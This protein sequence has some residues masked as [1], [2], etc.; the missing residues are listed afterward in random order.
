MIT[1]SRS[2]PVD[3]TFTLKDGGFE[4]FPSDNKTNYSSSRTVGAWNLTCG[5][6]IKQWQ[7]RLSDEYE[8]GKVLN[9][10]RGTT[11]APNGKAQQVFKLKKAG[12]YEYRVK[13]YATDDTW[14][15]YLP[16]ATV[17]QNLDLET[18]L[19]ESCNDT[20][21]NTK[22]IH[23]VFFG[24]N[25]AQGDSL[26]LYK[27]HPAVL[28]Y[29]RYTPQTYSVIYVKN[30]DNEEEF[31]LGFEVYDNHYDSGSNG[32]GFGDNHL[33]Y[34][35]SEAAYKTATQAAFEQECA[36]AR[37]MIAKYPKD[38]LN[39]GGPDLKKGLVNGMYRYMGDKDNHPVD[40]KTLIK[41]PTT[42]QE[43]QNAIISLQENQK[44]L[45]ELAT[46]I[47]P[48]DPETK[49]EDL[50]KEENTTG[51]AGIYTLTGVRI[52]SNVKNLP[53]GL[54]IINGKKVVIK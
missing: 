11:V 2:N 8:A 24:P 51:K 22:P 4:S 41:T 1:A 34:L 48:V 47:A 38:S 23:K 9:A 43:L 33:Y 46:Y 5:T 16:T 15:Q 20:I 29:T 3:L 26:A 31:E 44:L 6:D 36:N 54:Y 49:I 40:D 37:A 39:A 13:A 35:G 14:A 18:F 10:W 28:N 52:Q 45:E 19:S 32:F 50:L 27:S 21:Y 30:N 53:R 42:L 25:G 12:V 17:L 7:I